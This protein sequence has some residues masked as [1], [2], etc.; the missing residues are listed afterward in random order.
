M[1]SWQASYSRYIAIW[2][3]LVWTKKDRWSYLRFH[4]PRRTKDNNSI[5]LARY[6][7]M[8]TV[9]R[10]YPVHQRELN[11]QLSGDVLSPR[12]ISTPFNYNHSFSLSPLCSFSLD[13]DSFPILAT[14]GHWSVPLRICCSWVQMSGF[15]NVL[16]PCYRGFA[17]DL[18]I[19]IQT[20]HFDSSKISPNFLKIKDFTLQTLD[21]FG[22]VYAYNNKPVKI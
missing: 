9:A 3:L 19:L 20:A 8:T 7:R 18:F 15:S 14:K 5:V 1:R 22:V 16:I 21:T 17:G 13:I 6:V 12:I 11:V 10:W 4:S 2:E